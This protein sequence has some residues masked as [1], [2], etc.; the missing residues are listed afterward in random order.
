MVFLGVFT[1]SFS[2]IIVVRLNGAVGPVSLS[3]LRFFFGGLFLL[4]LMALMGDLKGMW[5]ILK[6]YPAL[7]IVSSTI[8]LGISNIIYF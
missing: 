4:L 6:R 1:W 8:G 5:I 7:S 3:F 2:E